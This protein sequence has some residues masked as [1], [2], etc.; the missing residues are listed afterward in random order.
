MND[1][2]QVRA[3]PYTPEYL[4][5]LRDLINLH[6]G[7]A[8]PG[9]WLPA[10]LIAATLERNRG[11]YIIDPWVAERA[12][13]VVGTPYRL[14]A[15]V[16]VL[17]YRDE[18]DVGPDYRGAGTIA[19]VVGRPDAPDALAAV[20]EAA[21]AQ[22]AAWGVEHRY[23]W[24]TDLPVPALVGVADAWPHVARALAAAGY[25]P[26]EVSESLY[27][28]RLDGIP[29]PGAP[30]LPGLIARRVVGEYSGALFL[31]ELEGETIGLCEVTADLTRGG[32][33]PGL[34]GW[35]EL[36]E[37][38]VEE[39]WRGRGVG[40]WLLRHG[41]EWLRL[42]GCGRI[43]LAVGADDDARGAGRFYRRFGWDVFVRETR[44]WRR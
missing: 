38:H 20:L 5:A 10:D 32:E 22:F 14:R 28:G 1:E 8:V 39:R 6:L 42:A 16:H 17:R 29:L 40:T 13:F 2:R 31:G 35:G 11:Q 44:S 3:E 43:V 34:R 18:D 25:T 23:G 24:D 12:T 41:V 21:H 37:M 15:A 36:D 7:A 27:G 19:W 4:H 33:R 26:G 9:W 30:P